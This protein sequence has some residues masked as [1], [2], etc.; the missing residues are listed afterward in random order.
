MNGNSRPVATIVATAP[1]M[2]T[3]SVPLVPPATMSPTA[4]PH[5]STPLSRRSRDGRASGV[6]TT[7][8]AATG[9]TASARRAAPRPAIIATA[10]PATRPAA[11]GMGVTVADMGGTP[12]MSPA[13]VLTSSAPAPTPSAAPAS[14]PIAPVIAASAIT[15]AGDLPAGGTNGA[16]QRELA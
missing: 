9:G 1:P 7:R 3:D 10:I 6:D 2:S 15:R 8:M 14:A 11:I 5:T 12:G 4:V 16:Q 13:E